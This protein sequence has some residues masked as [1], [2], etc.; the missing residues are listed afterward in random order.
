LRVLQESGLDLPFII[1]S[2]AIGE[3]T[4]V[5]AMK[6][7]AHDY[8][9]KHNLAR[10]VPAVE[11]ELREAEGRAK[12]RRAEEMLAAEARFLRAQTEVAQVALSS[13]DPGVLLPQLLE[14][15]CRVQGYD[16]GFLARIVADGH[17]AVTLACC[18]RGASPFLG[19]RQ[20]L[21][22]PTSFM[23]HTLRTG[24]PAFYNGL[25]ES[26]FAP[27]PITRT[28]RPQAS[29]AL[30]LRHRSGGLIGLLSFADTRNPERFTEQDLTQGAILASQ[31][32]QA[33]EN[34][35][36]FCQVRQLQDQYRV[37]T[38]SL[39]DAIYTVDVEGRITFSNTALERLTGYRV[40]EL[41]GRPSV[42]LYAAGGLAEIMER[43]QRLRSG[44]RVPSHLETEIVRSDGS[45]VPV[46]L[47]TDNLILGGQMAG[48]VIVARDV[49]ERRS[50]E[51]QLRRAQKLEAVGELAAGVAHELGNALGIIGGAVQYLL[52][53]C[54][55]DHPYGECLE[56]I[57]RNVAQADRTIRG[58]LFFARPRHPAP[59]PVNLVHLIEGTLRLLKSELAKFNIGVITRF[60]QDVPPVIAD[61]EQLQQVLLNLLLN[62]I[63]AMPQGGSIILTT[64]VETEGNEG[65]I[66]V[67]DT[68]LGIPPEH[69]SRI[70]DPFFTTKEGGTGLGLAVSDRLIRAQGGRIAVWSKLDQGSVFTIVLPA[71]PQG[72][73]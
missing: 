26:R 12:H 9:M 35:E 14:T 10:L 32:A 36:L 56:V 51:E 22:D 33:L 21:N 6:A 69:L 7:G 43:R 73:V 63:Q 23:A 15:V 65:Q 1:V 49:T 61:A 27:H 41:H 16:Y 31:V 40:E 11:R 8:L 67:A 2:G 70:F 45:R 72:G 4:A 58:L 29:L 59:A 66:T 37:V 25:Q 46:E 60:G 64:N 71:M 34:S 20:D 47:S 52:R 38:E 17:E 18:G 55:A 68:G 13:L 24:L 39:N 44:K 62:A 28:L 57:R 54:A 30:P 3:D 5:A 50:L 53:S 42:E 48:R 19:F